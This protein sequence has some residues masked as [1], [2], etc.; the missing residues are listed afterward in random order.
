MIVLSPPLFKHARFKSS[1]AREKSQF[2]VSNFIELTPGLAT[3]HLDAKTAFYA[4]LIARA[5]SDLEPN[6]QAPSPRFK[7]D[8]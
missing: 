2:T 7:F 4:N 5:S 1:I 8:E 3:D 6:Y